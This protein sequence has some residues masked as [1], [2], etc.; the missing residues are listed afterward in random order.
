[1]PGHTKTISVVI[2]P[3]SELASA[4]ITW[5]TIEGEA[6]FSTC[7]YTIFLSGSPLALAVRTKSSFVVAS[8]RL[9]TM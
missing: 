8:V 5:V 9:L 1:M 3:P 4:I 6:V 7:P 2:P